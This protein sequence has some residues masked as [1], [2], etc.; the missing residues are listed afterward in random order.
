M[1][2]FVVGGLLLTDAETSPF[3]QA[4]SQNNETDSSGA[5]NNGTEG[6]PASSSETQQASTES[7]PKVPST[8][9][10]PSTSE[11][12]S[13]Q[14]SR[15]EADELIESWLQ[16]KRRIFAPPF[17][18]QLLDQL[19]TGERYRGNSGTIGWLQRNNGYYDYGVQKVE[20]IERIVK[21]GKEATVRFNYTEDR[22]LYLNGQVVPKETDFKT[23][24]VIYNLRFEEGR[25]KIASAKVEGWTM[26]FRQRKLSGLGFAAISILVACLLISIG[27]YNMPLSIPL[28]DWGD[29]AQVSKTSVQDKKLGTDSSERQQ[30]SLGKQARYYG[31]LA[32]APADPERMTLVASY[33]TGEYQ[34]FKSMHPNA[35]KALMRMIYAARDDGAWIVPV[36]GFRT[37]E[38]QNELFQEQVERLGSKQEAAKASAPPGYSEHIQGLQSI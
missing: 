28:V 23:R 24:T 3:R 9:P 5:E 19:T 32:Y 8:Q 12:D 16:A 20:S 7:S 31:H 1:G 11:S 13:P 17:S 15:Q 27:I 2:L 18:R 6:E 34:R 26:E 4:A 25:W 30:T 22:T 29:S 21:N 36:S 14:L 37:W 33:A 38:R 35:A 10:S